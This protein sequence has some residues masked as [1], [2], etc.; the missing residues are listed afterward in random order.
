MIDDELIDLK[1]NTLFFL[2]KKKQ[3]FRIVKGEDLNGYSI[4]I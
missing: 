1:P 4:R 3:I 2:F